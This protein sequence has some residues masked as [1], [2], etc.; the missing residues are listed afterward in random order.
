MMEKENVDGKTT[1]TEEEKEAGAQE[2][3]RENVASAVLGKFKDVD[4][5]TR[6]YESLQA[7]FT[8]RS[9]RLRTLEKEME[10]F[11]RTDGGS[12]AEKLRKTASVRREATQRFDAFVAEVGKPA[13]EE[14]PRSLEEKPVETAAEAATKA[15]GGEEIAEESACAEE[16]SAQE[17]AKGAASTVGSGSV[18]A[19]SEELFRLA[20]ADEG[21]RLR[22]IGEYLA[23]LGR[24]NAPMM[25][26]GAGTLATPPARAKTVGE[27]GVM[28]LSYF[29]KPTVD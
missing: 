18:Y 4:A 27:A 11:K 19:S 21:V 28:A 2:S 10:N 23:S 29:R 20:H 13:L 3:A 9:Q 1:W 12:G 22:I 24:S 15:E 16:T 14:K 25:T 17:R 8:R 26:G 7:E 5:L 6:A